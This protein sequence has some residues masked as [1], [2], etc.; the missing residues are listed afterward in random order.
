MYPGVYLQ[1]TGVLGREPQLYAAVATYMSG[2]RIPGGILHGN[3]KKPLV[4]WPLA[5]LAF[6]S[7]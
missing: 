5:D 3:F 2:L 7:H 1:V 6:I 4:H